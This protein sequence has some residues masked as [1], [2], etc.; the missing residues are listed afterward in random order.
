MNKGIIREL[1]AEI[2]SMY[3]GYRFDIVT[4]TSLNSY[5]VTAYKAHDNLS[6]ITFIP[7]TPLSEFWISIK[8]WMLTVFA[9]R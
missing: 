5:I 3:P 7:E 6:S 4:N 2:N 8:K 9:I 1:K